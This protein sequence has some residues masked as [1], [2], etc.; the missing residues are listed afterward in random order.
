MTELIIFY[1]FETKALFEAILSN[2]E[3]YGHWCEVGSDEDV[4]A[5]ELADQLHEWQLRVL[6]NK[7]EA[8]Q[9]EMIL[10]AIGRVNWRQL[11]Q[12]VQ[13]EAAKTLAQYELEQQ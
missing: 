9:R 11:A 3:D 12:L 5:A 4:S 7:A 13:Q 10:L 2:S 6:S 1:N 8:W